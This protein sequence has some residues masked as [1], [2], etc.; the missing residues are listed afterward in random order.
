MIKLACLAILQPLPQGS[1]V[2][3]KVHS[4]IHK[5]PARKLKASKV[6][7]KTINWSESYSGQ[8]EQNNDLLFDS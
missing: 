4:H 7:Q 3:E 2:W 5:T 6:I 8:Q 1:Y